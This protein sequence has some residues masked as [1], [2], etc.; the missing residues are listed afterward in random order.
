MTYLDINGQVL[1]WLQCWQAVSASC[2]R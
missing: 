2:L 1:L